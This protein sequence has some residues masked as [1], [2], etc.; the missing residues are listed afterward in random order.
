M[1]NLPNQ[2]NSVLETNLSNNFFIEFKNNLKKNYPQKIFLIDSLPER[3]F[4]AN[5]S[6]E[7]LE[8]KAEIINNLISSVSNDYLIE[9]DN[10]DLNSY[11]INVL[12]DLIDSLLE[13]EDDN[14]D[15][16]SKILVKTKKY[17][18]LSN[19]GF[20]EII[21]FIPDN[22]YLESDDE[23]SFTNKRMIFEDYI[24]VVLG[25][26]K[27][28]SSFMKNL[29][30]LLRK[31]LIEIDPNQYEILNT[32]PINF[33]R[34]TDSNE[35][36]LEKIKILANYK[37]TLSNDFFDNSDIPEIVNI[38]IQV[39]KDI[40]ADAIKNNKEIIDKLDSKLSKI[41]DDLFPE[42]NNYTDVLFENFIDENDI[43]DLLE[44]KSNI[45]DDFL[46][47]LSQGDLSDLEFNDK[48]M[49]KFIS[50]V[51]KFDNVMFEAINK[52]FAKFPEVTSSMEELEEKI[53]AINEVIKTC[54]TSKGSIYNDLYEKIKNQ[55]N[56]NL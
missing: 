42:N 29:F 56:S 10:K 24:S 23:K 43:S 45:L 51:K 12:N 32:L 6:R 28:K 44:F 50:Q 30:P 47:D 55:N 14:L 27:N 2:Y 17:L 9:S 7:F 18:K 40:E 34:D 49:N 22:F 35:E 20:D 33:F 31:T 26:K 21:D 1:N 38:K 46:E 25:D 8:Y 5:E 19:Q 54:K 48:I 52:S 3:F 41:T 13:S 15:F 53:N 37:N 39:L 4:L 11:K 36:F 16:V